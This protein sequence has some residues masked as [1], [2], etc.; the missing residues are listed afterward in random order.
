M[1]G[2]FQQALLQQLARQVHPLFL[3]VFRANAER[4][5]GLVPELEHLF[6][7][8][9]HQQVGDMPGAEAFA[10]APH[11][12][13]KLLRRDGQVNLFLALD[14]AAVITVAAVFGRVGLTEIIEQRHAPA[15]IRFGISGHIAQVLAGVAAFGF[16]FVFDKVL[17]LVRVGIAVEQQAVRRQSIAPGAPDLLIITLDIARQVVVQDKAH[18][19]FVDAHAEGNRGDDD[20]HV[21]TDEQFLVLLAHLV[22]Q[23]GV[24]GTH[25]KAAPR[26][27]ICQFFHLTA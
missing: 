20:L 19:G 11:A 5:Q 14:A 4:R 1:L 6:I 9:P 24:I 2:A 26:Q 10:A 16:I 17:D 13:H 15:D 27:H 22:F 18:V 23:P 3:A 21:V 25:R 8:D 7:L 12:G